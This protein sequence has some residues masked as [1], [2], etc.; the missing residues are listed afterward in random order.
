MEG[1]PILDAIA[2]QQVAREAT[3]QHFRTQGE[4]ST[5]PAPTITT[6]PVNVTKVEDIWIGGICYCPNTSANV[7]IT[8]LPELQGELPNWAINN[9]DWA[10]SN[11]GG[12][13]F[14][15]TDAILVASADQTALISTNLVEIPFFLDSGASNHISCS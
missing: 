4:P 15:D 2:C 1:M 7:A 8:K 11:T 3:R 5:A 12:D 6:T 9:P 10:E 14:L 13:T